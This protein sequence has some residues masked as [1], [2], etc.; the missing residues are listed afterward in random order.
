MTACTAGS[1]VS[2]SGRRSLSEAQRAKLHSL[3]AQPVDEKGK[4]FL[5]SDRMSLAQVPAV[6]T[7]FSAK[8]P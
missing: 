2:L 7:F 4:A 1:V 3:R 5:Y 8:E 6:A